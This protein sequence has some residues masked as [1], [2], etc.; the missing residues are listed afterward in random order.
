MRVHGWTLLVLGSH[1]CALVASFP[2]SSSSQNGRY[3]R[4]SVLWSWS[5]QAFAEQGSINV[6]SPVLEGGDLSSARDWLEHLPDGAYTV[7]RADIDLDVTVWGRSFHTDR[8]EESCCTLAELQ[9]TQRP[10]RKSLDAARIQTEL[11]I[12]SLLQQA[13]LEAAGKPSLAMIAVLWHPRTYQTGAIQVGGHVQL[14]PVS[15]SP[16]HSVTVVA[17]VG[18]DL[19]NRQPYPQAKLSSW[20]RNRRPIEQRFK[21]T[22]IGEALLVEQVKDKT[23]LLEGLTSN[24]FVLRSNGV[25]QT[26]PSSMVLGGYARHLVLAQAKRLGIPIHLEAPCIEE[27]H[28]WKECFLTSAVR[29]VVPVRELLAPVSS[30]PHREPVSWQSHWKAKENDNGSH[31]W[32]RLYDEMQCSQRQV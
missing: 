4:Q 8:L 15:P 25:L 19:P 23:L 27:C 17:S 16:P 26:A 5:R 6:S 1:L 21:L 2:T 12:D 18:T 29:L 3:Y 32:R 9:G 30:S 10:S 13:E 20:C 24:L 14:L 11:V 28:D 22:G 7:L 31:L